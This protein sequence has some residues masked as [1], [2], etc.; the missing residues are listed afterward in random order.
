MD[1]YGKLICAQIWGSI[2]S[3]CRL[4]GMPDL[5]MS[6]SSPDLLQ[7]TCFHP[8]VRLARWNSNKS[9]SFVPPDG[10]FTLMQYRLATPTSPAFLPLQLRPIITLGSSGGGF[11]L[12][13][14]SRNP[15][16]RP[17][18]NV[19]LLLKLGTNA[20]SVQ[21]TISGG[22]SQNRKEEDL[23][24]GRWEFD[25]LSGWLGWL[26]PKLSSSDKP[27]VFEGTW[28]SSFVSTLFTPL[29]FIHRTGRVSPCPNPALGIQAEFESA[30]TNV[31][32]IQIS[33]LKIVS[34]GAGEQLYKG[35]RPML[36]SGRLEYR[37]S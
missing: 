4:S 11:Q 35:V 19:K 32:G 12:T 29:V 28:N 22:H 33:N 21:A 26:V 34:Q 3:K 14:S 2:E 25:P 1:R 23:P 31:S 20:T 13:M 9:L 36:K 5:L 16:S 7:D 30:L 17:L 8:C 24:G 10:K 15:S 6:L 37:W 18:E 27:C